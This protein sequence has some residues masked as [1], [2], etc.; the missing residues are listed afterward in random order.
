MRLWNAES[1]TVKGQVSLEPWIALHTAKFLHRLLRGQ[2]KKKKKICNFIIALQVIKVKESES[3]APQSSQDLC[4]PMDCSLPLSVR[5]ILQARVGS[6][7]P[8]PFPEAFPDPGLPHCR[9]TLHR[10]SRQRNPALLNTC[11]MG[12][13]ELHLHHLWSSEWPR[14]AGGRPRR[15][16]CRAEPIQPL[17][18][19]KCPSL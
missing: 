6:G 4:N 7:L 9:Q 17:K 14:G 12:S 2:K 13:G 16:V 5:G 11:L 19:C 3:D 1:R 18:P 15:R 8:F 10:L